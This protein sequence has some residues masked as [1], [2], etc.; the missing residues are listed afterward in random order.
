MSKFKLILSDCVTKT[1]IY[2]WSKI[3]ILFQI[4]VNPL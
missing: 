4:V 2:E 3:F 1:A